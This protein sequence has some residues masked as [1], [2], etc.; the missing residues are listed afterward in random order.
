MNSDSQKLSQLESRTSAEAATVMGSAVKRLR[1]GGEW[2]KVGGRFP[3]SGFLAKRLD[4]SDGRA[5]PDR[6]EWKTPRTHAGS[7]DY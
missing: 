6:E 2:Q 5:G 7:L 4:Q 3:T 1:R